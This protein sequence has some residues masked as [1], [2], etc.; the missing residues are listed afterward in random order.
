M[1]IHCKNTYQSEISFTEGRLHV[2]GSLHLIQKMNQ[3]KEKYGTNP[4]AWPVVSELKTSDDLLINEFI[5]KV[6]DQFAL[7]YPHEE[8][9]HCRMVAGEKVYQAI[10]QGCT[11]VDEVARATLAGT[12]C[13]SCRPDT[14]KLLDQ[15]KLS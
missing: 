7:S 9:C 4:D 8:L 1:V 11:T 14:Q 3:L 15:F 5:L 13:G 12:G 10:K 2:V 6:K